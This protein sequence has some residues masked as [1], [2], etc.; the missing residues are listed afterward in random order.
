MHRSSLWCHG[1]QSETE[2][3][4]FLQTDL[5]QGSFNTDAALYMNSD[6]QIFKVCLWCAKLSEAWL[7]LSLGSGSVW[8]VKHE[9]SKKLPPDTAHE[10]AR[11][12]LKGVRGWAF[13]TATFRDQYFRTAMGHKSKWKPGYKHVIFKDTW[14][15]CCLTVIQS[16]HVT[17]VV[18]QLCLIFKTTCRHKESTLANN[19]A[20][21]LDKVLGQFSVFMLQQTQN[22]FILSSDDIIGLNCSQSCCSRVSQPHTLRAGQSYGT[23]RSHTKNCTFT[24]NERLTEQNAQD[25]SR[26]YSLGRN[27]MT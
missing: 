14:R 22:Y 1:F 12:R 4:L 21:L 27:Q 3:A 16:T 8:E 20:Q 7:Q 26:F 25:K 9:S 19:H 13:M 2:I 17:A 24:N 11:P 18:V 23:V 15:K 5:W 10:W 6:Q